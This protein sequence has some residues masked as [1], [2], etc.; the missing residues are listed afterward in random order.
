MTVDGPIG[1]DVYPHR[2]TVLT[3]EARTAW[4]R[5]RCQQ[6]A[7]FY[8]RLADTLQSSGPQARLVLACKQLLPDPSADDEV[9][10]EI[11][12]RGRLAELLA[13]RG[14]DFSLLGDAPRVVVLKSS[15]WHASANAEEDLLDDVL[16]PTASYGNA[17]HFPRIGV[18]NYRPPRQVN[19]ANCVFSAAGQPDV[20]RLSV[21][22]SPNARASRRRFVLRPGRDQRADDLRGGLDR[23]A[24]TG[25]GDRT[26]A[27]D[28]A[29][30]STHPV[31]Q[32]GRG[33]PVGHRS[34]RPTQQEDLYLRRQRV[35]SAVRV[36]ARALLSAGNGLS[37]ARPVAR[38]IDWT[39]VDWTSIE[40]AGIVRIDERRLGRQR[41]EP[42]AYVARRFRAGGLGNRSRRR[43]GDRR[44]NAA[45]AGRPRA[46][47]GAASPGFSSN[48][49]SPDEASRRS[50]ML[51]RLPEGMPRGIPP[52][53][54]E[55]RGKP[56]RPCTKLPPTPARLN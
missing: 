8:Q 18:L 27:A 20:T 26:P 4:V 28:R 21:E 45:A 15:V 33:R 10:H 37:S 34:G 6:M 49:P 32:S 39:S 38:C 19:I 40:R 14:L 30:H 3:G 56:F 54:A 24:G 47:A 5:W 55:R 22:A 9:R 13:D 42:S 12:V 52:H 25:T 35:R 31:L 1:G 17:F 11:R 16:S 53:R 51:R 29:G 46:F 43:A 50:Q 7:K 44:R 36:V 41:Y 23:S 2:H 48:W